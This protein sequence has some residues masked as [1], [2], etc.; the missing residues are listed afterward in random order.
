MELPRVQKLCLS[1]KGSVWNES[2]RGGGDRFDGNDLGGDEAYGSTPGED[3]LHGVRT[4]WGWCG[5]L[6]S[7]RDADPGGE[8]GESQRRRIL[9]DE[10]TDRKDQEE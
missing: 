1:R 3:S 5:I 9:R 10:S 2:I 6:L 7:G 8:F 4:K